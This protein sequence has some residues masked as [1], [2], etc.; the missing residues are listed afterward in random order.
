[1]LLHIAFKELKALGKMLFRKTFR[2]LTRSDY[3]FF[4]KNTLDHSIKEKKINYLMFYEIH[5]GRKN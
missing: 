5:V 2:R 1:M 3:S 4:N